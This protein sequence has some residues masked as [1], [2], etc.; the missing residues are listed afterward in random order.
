MLPAAEEA[1]LAARLAELERTSKHQFVIVSV[2]SLGG[3]DVA[4]YGLQLANYWGV[5]RAGVNDGVV[6]LVAPNERKTR[7]E[8]GY[9][10]E[11]ALTDKEAETIMQQAILPRFSTG[12]MAEGIAAGSEAIIRE[13]TP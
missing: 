12:R 8:V 10:L 7:I 11:K 13:I 9:G 3:H 4:D 5:G 2:R 6:L 1:K